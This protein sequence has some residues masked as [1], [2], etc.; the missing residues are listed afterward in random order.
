ML[1]LTDGKM[2][3]NKEVHHG[4]KAMRDMFEDVL[5][6][7]GD[8]R[9]AMESQTIL[10]TSLLLEIKDWK[11]SSRTVSSQC[12]AV[13][14]MRGRIHLRRKVRN[15]ERCKVLFTQVQGC[16]AVAYWQS[17]ETIHDSAGGLSGGPY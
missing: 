9:E 11:N 16:G 2:P 13:R 4:R 6:D 15:Q 10:W 14:G 1:T 3:F 7:S 12:S 8:G 5:Q 17:R